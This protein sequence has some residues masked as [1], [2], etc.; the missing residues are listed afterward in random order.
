[1]TTDA[2]SGIYRSRMT[3]NLHERH[4]D[5]RPLPGRAQLSMIS[6][7]NPERQREERDVHTTIRDHG[8]RKRG[9]QNLERRGKG[10]S[11]RR[12]VPGEEQHHQPNRGGKLR[13]PPSATTGPTIRHGREG[14][15]LGRPA[16]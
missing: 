8:D 9:D 12:V 6:K 4:G 10:A 5:D 1:V 15:E 14:G 16:L 2:L 3:A 13:S 11:R 7:P